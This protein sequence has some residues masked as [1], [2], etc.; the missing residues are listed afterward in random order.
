MY[1]IISK[2]GIIFSFAKA[3]NSFAIPSSLRMITPFSIKITLHKILSVILSISN[4][5]ASGKYSHFP[6][7][8]FGYT[9]LASSYASL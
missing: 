9:N 1:S 7:P 3:K 5:L 2:F 6:I 8:A 4:D